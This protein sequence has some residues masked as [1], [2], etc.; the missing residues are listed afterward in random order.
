MHTATSYRGPQKILAINMARDAQ[1]KNRLSNQEATHHMLGIG[2][3]PK[4]T[5]EF[6]GPQGHNES[7]NNSY[8]GHTVDPLWS[9][10]SQ[11]HRLILGD[12]SA[13][14]VVVILC[15][16]VL[17]VEFCMLSGR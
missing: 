2:R 7:T 14:C 8:W 6:H 12:V 10:R 5:A 13:K 3:L 16:A 15:R 17:L 11:H 1:K 4:L 9:Y